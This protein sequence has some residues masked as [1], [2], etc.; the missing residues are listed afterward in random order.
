MALN[1]DISHV[2]IFCVS[3]SCRVCH[4]LPSSGLSRPILTLQKVSYS[5]ASTQSQDYWVVRLQRQ[6]DHAHGDSYEECT[7]DPFV[8]PK[9]ACTGPMKTYVPPQGNHK[10]HKKPRDILGSD[11]LIV[12]EQEC[13]D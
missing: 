5:S 2:Q 8:F 1:L 12:L 9:A 7:E 11:T 3:T 4:L 6:Q 13:C 10:R